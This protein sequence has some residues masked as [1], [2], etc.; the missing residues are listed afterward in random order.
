RAVGG[1]RQ[2]PSPEV[3]Q[4]LRHEPQPQLLAQAE[5]QDDPGHDQ[6]V[7]LQ[8]QPVAGPAPAGVARRPPHPRPVVARHGLAW[9]TRSSGP[10]WPSCRGTGTYSRPPSGSKR[11]VRASFPVAIF[12]TTA[13]S[14]AAARSITA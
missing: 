9:K 14:P 10:P 13:Y 7:G 2:R 1:D 3:L 12:S 5:D 8:P 4:V 6:D 11:P